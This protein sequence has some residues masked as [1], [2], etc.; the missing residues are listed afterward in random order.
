MVSLESRHYTAKL[1]MKQLSTVGNMAL[2]YKHVHA[3]AFIL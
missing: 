3:H 1:A 2:L